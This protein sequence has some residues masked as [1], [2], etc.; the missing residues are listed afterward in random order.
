MDFMYATPTSLVQEPEAT[1]SD[2][3]PMS[4]RRSRKLKSGIRSHLSV[5]GS[6]VLSKGTTVPAKSGGDWLTSIV[7]EMR[8]QPSFPLIA[9]TWGFLDLDQMVEKRS[10][11]SDGLVSRFSPATFWTSSRNWAAAS[12]AAILPEL[13]MRQNVSSL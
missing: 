6:F 3:E 10:S 8:G 13:P 2:F 11:Y 9:E 7:V 12:R 1:L 5:L 4:Q